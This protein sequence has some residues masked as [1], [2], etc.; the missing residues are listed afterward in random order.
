MVYIGF[1]LSKLN[2]Y[3]LIRIAKLKTPFCLI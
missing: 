2:K 3:D 1:A